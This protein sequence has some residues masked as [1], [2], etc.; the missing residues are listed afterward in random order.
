MISL[1]IVGLL[2]LTSLA[3]NDANAVQ[4]S[5]QPLDRA[6]PPAGMIIQSYARGLAGICT[7]PQNVR[8]SVGDDPSLPHERV[9]T[10][11]YPTR[12]TDPAGRDV[13]CVA[14]NQDWSTGRAIA[15]QIKADR[16]SRLSVSFL[17]RHQVAYTKR[18]EVQGGGWHLVRIPFDDIRPN[19]FFQPA[20]AKTG[21]PLDVSDVKFIAFAPQDDTSG[22]FVIGT[23]VLEK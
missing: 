4:R 5:A 6:E 2:V 12:T 21:A 8:L 22:R 7:A 23:F 9:M 3:S 10:V 16:P 17:D 11:E 13:R 19:Q 1:P 18:V 14:E 20:D 15:F